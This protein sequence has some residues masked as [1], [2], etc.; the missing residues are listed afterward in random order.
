LE[1]H[2]REVSCACLQRILK[3]RADAI[4]FVDECDARHFVFR[5]LTPDGFGLRLHAGNAA[6]HGDRAVKHAHGTFD[7][8]GKIHVAG[9]VNDV[10][11]M[12]NVVKRLVNFIFARLAVFCV[13]KQVTAALVIVIPRSRSCSIQSVTVLPSSNRRFCGSAGVKGYARRRRF[14]ASCARQCDVTSALHRVFTF[15]RIDRTQFIFSK[16]SAHIFNK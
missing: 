5:R 7:F 9:R 2:T 12:R 3:I 1:T 16:N 6:K 14:A 4:H 13:Q 10:D 11:A 15:G 8:G